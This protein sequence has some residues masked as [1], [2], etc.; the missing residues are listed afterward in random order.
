VLSVSQYDILTTSKNKNIQVKICSKTEQ[1]LCIFIR[2][3][4]ADSC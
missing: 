3:Q 4:D 2:N 1:Y